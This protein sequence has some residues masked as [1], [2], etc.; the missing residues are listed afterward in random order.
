[1]CSYE[2]RIRAVELD[3]KLGKRVRPTLRQLGYPTKNALTG[4]Y[5]EYE[6]RL[7]LPVGYVGRKPKYSQAQ[8]E[9]AIALS[10]SRSMHG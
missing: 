6:H 7:D 1:M 2:D 9:A 3:I 4:W 5:W 10:Q 8:K